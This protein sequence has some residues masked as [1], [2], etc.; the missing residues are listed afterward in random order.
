MTI[1]AY[2][3]P[4]GN[5]CEKCGWLAKEHRLPCDRP[6]RK[7]RPAKKDTRKRVRKKGDPF[8]YIGVDGEG[9]GK[10]EFEYDA[11]GGM[12]RLVKPHRYTL[13]AWSNFD[14]V[15]S[16]VIR[17]PGGLNTDDCLDFLLTIPKD[18]K[19][20]AYAFNYDLT[21]L[22][23]DLDDDLLYLLFRP[24]QRRNSRSW[25]R[26]VEWRDFKLNLVGA[27]FTLEYKKHKRVIWD[28]FKFYQSRF[29]KAL[30]DWGVADKDHLAMMERMKSER[31]NFDLYS[32]AEIESYCLEECRYMATLAEKLV[33]A[34]NAAGLKLKNFFGAG[35]SA[36]AILDKMGIHEERREGLDDMRQAIASAFFGGRFENSRIGEIE[37]P[38]WGYDISS[39]YPYQTT[40]LPCLECGTW[41]KSGDPLELLGSD[42]RA[43]L[44]R[45]RLNPSAEPVPWGPFPFRGEDGSI[46]FPS[47]SGGG[48]VWLDEY[49][50]GKKLCEGVEFMEA[51]L[52][53][54]ECDHR[55]FARIPHYYLERLKLGKEGPGI[56]IKL[57]V[58]AV[59]GK[60]A[61]SVGSPRYQSWVWAGM[62]TA[63]TRAQILDLVR[64][65]RDRNNLLMVATD[66][67]YTR[68]RLS[69]PK[70]RDTGTFGVSKPLGGWEEK[71][72][73][74]GVLLVRPGIYCPRYEVRELSEREQ[75]EQAAKVRARGIGRGLLYKHWRAISRA[76]ARGEDG[77][78]LPD[79]VRFLGA[80]TS[81]SRSVNSE[82]DGDTPLY[83]YKRSVA[84]GQWVARPIEMTFAPMPKRA[85]ILPDGTLE[86]RRVS[87]DQESAPYSK[88]IAP[89]EGED[90]ETWEDELA[91]QPEGGD[92]SDYS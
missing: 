55:P 34:H 81:I 51:W 86:I 4:L 70:P 8:F 68:E 82:C 19:A 54:S 85:G 57:A 61:Q 78:R 3:Y 60:L 23:A 14:G 32:H 58:N 7:K 9:Q 35:S 63:G 17:N 80:K 5:P 53:R 46:C 47:Q 18:A 92:F 65:H 29:T 91:E 66:G 48:W 49:L 20:F 69:T 37:G 73:P 11:Q 41:R 79:G 75:D 76:I 16:N 31:A 59:Y 15:L 45:Y 10:S 24:D 1:M 64:I 36:S 50:A 74:E 13:L 89:R 43:G 21:K 25:S 6:P 39:A 62:V 88:A 52:Y 71:E 84:Y 28:I 42:V 56:V 33:K 90:L 77:Y 83:V 30:T 87:M 26:P 22:L 44:V 27:K 40:F 38:V 67:I 72:I 2:H 12:I